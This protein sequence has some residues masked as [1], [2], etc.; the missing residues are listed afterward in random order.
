MRTFAQVVSADVA[1]CVGCRATRTAVFL[2]CRALVA[3]REAVFHC[4]DETIY[5]TEPSNQ[6]LS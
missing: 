4:H 2:L 1:D 3:S 6:R 5:V